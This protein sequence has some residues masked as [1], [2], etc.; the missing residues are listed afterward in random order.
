MRDSPDSAPIERL[1]SVLNTIVRRDDLA[2]AEAPQRLSGGYSADLFAFRLANP[3]D[4]LDGALVVRL[5]HD[6]S[7]AV[8]EAVIQRAVADLGFP[9]PRVR[10]SGDS[11]AGLGRPFVVMDRARGLY[12]VTVSG[13]RSAWR[14]FQRIPFVLADTMAALH[15][16]DA[17]VVLDQLTAS[18]CA[19]APLGADAVLR[20][21]ESQVPNLSG[22]MT[23]LN[24]LLK[25]RPAPPARPVVCHGDL[26]AFNLLAVE[27]EITAVLDWELATVADNE[28]DVARTA[29]LLSFVPGQMSAAVRP[30]V[31]ALG[32]R[33]ARIFG[34]AYARFHH[35][36]DV[37]LHWHE[38][39]HCLRLIA[40]VAKNRVDAV[41]NPV[42]RLWEPLVP[43]LARRFERIT[44]V[45]VKLQLRSIAAH[46]GG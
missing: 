1:L 37:S 34:A 11:A 4:G 21:I 29:V 27:S 24:W 20:E 10:M 26:H 16:L 3:P 32:R 42:A 41:G 18:G 43:G 33:A 45:S 36:D 22:G 9:A 12:P 30:V 8:R 40:V 38:A 14:A 25:H 2:Y 7:A 6:D 17:R 28:F 31:Q 39:L 46:L 19:A 5:M 15:A 13:P 35:I 44:G 23:G